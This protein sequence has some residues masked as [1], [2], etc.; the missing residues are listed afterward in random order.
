MSIMPQSPPN[1]PTI[2]VEIFKFMGSVLPAVLTFIGSRFPQKRKQ[3]MS[4]PEQFSENIENQLAE[5]EKQGQTYAVKFVQ[6]VKTTRE[7]FIDIGYN[8][9]SSLI[10]NMKGIQLSDKDFAKLEILNRQY[11]M[12]ET[13][14]KFLLTDFQ[15]F[16]ICMRDP[17]EERFF[18]IELA[19]TEDEVNRIV[20]HN[21]PLRDVFDDMIDL[22]L[23]LGT[24][25]ISDGGSGNEPELV[26]V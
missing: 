18:A 5:M 3:A 26:G 4:N 17:E 2:I 15:R 19:E 8:L 13:E 23:T 11:R 1:D 21:R 20:K 6:M 9:N 24:E 14:L 16:I 10:D 12:L 25:K 7:G 22:A